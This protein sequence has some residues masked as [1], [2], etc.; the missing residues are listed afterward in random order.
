MIKLGTIIPYLKKTENVYDSRD[1]HL[2]SADVSIFSPEVSKF[3]YIKK[4]RYW[5]N[6]H[7]EFLTLNFFL[8]FKDFFIKHDYNF[9][10][11]SKIDHFS[12]S[13]NKDILK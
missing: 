7:T 6:F 3:C 12:P 8:I 1:T 5:L 9:D 11:V 2:T 13:K 4:Y 10:Y